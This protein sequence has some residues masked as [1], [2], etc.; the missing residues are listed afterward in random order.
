MWSP[1]RANGAVMC[2]SFVL[3]VFLPLTG[4]VAFH[5]RK[6]N[7]RIS[8]MDWSVE[9]IAVI[10]AAEYSSARA[11][12]ALNS[13]TPTETWIFVPQP[14]KSLA[15]STHVAS[16]WFV[17]Q[18]YRK[19]QNC[20]VSRWFASVIPRIPKVRWG[21][22]IFNLNYSLINPSIDSRECGGRKRKTRFLVFL[23]PTWGWTY[24]MEALWHP[25]A[26][27]GHRFKLVWNR[28]RS[29]DVVQ[30][31]LGKISQNR[32]KADIICKS[33]ASHG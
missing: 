25:T 26:R 2:I 21:A 14:W 15:G 16:S 9:Q 20:F 17:K 23:A 13:A 8:R 4:Y 12:T 1:D 11:R 10:P 24:R 22:R 32:E 3:P 31:E 6:Y 19:T 18:N 27:I 5:S 29:Q 28:F 30:R 7:P 33:Q